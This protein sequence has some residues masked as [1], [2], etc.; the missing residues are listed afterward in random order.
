M[1]GLF[2]STAHRKIQEDRS[3]K[4]SSA[5][6]DQP[7]CCVQED[8]Y[9]AL[10]AARIEGLD[11]MFA[12]AASKALFLGPRCKTDWLETS[13]RADVVCTWSER[14]RR[15]SI[16]NLDLSRH[17]P[18]AKANETVWRGSYMEAEEPEDRSKLQ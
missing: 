15:A 5:E 9:K 17:C 1:E 13:R 8:K 3:T 14:D 12:K 2:L 4:C 18:P 10:R 6:N 11:R 16:W 7:V